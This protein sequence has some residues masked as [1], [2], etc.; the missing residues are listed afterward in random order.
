MWTS[1]PH[2]SPSK[3][4]A[5][6][7]SLTQQPSCTS[8]AAPAASDAGADVVIDLHGASHLDPEVLL[9]LRRL[10]DAGHLPCSRCR[11]L[12]R[13]R[14][15]SFHPR[16]AGGA[17]NLPPA[18][19]RRRRSP[20]RTRHRLPPGPRRRRRERRQRSC[21][22]ARRRA[23]LRIRTPGWGRPTARWPRKPAAPATLAPSTGWRFRS[24]S[25]E[26]WILRPRS[27]HCPTRRCASSRTPSTATSTPAARLSG[28]TPGT[29]LRP[30][31]FR[32]AT[33]SMTVARQED[34]LA[35]DT[36]L[37]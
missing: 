17:A 35:P 7:P 24:T 12:R 34:E 4:P 6:L 22:T 23:R 27:G 16:R 32:T 31:S 15:A 10:A 1:I 26:R 13:G 20:R 29:S 3:L 5:A 18:R 2:R 21:R 14:A 25:R 37:A 8:C 9:D 36:A 33:C 19:R 28:R 30:K 11:G